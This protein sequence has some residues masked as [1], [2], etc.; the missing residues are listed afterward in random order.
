[1]LLTAAESSPWKIDTQPVLVPGM[2]GEWDDWAIASPTILKR[3]G[4]WWMFYEGVIFDEQ[5]VRSSF[6]TAE[7]T[8][9][10]AW[11]KHSQ[12]PLFTPALSES[13]TCSAPSA[14]LWHDAF[15]AIY[16]VSEDPFRVDLAAQN[17]GDAP[18]TARLARSEDGLIWHD[19]A[20][21]NPPVASKTARAFQPCLYADGDSLHLWW[22]GP[23]AND[24]PAL[25]HSISRDGL[26]WS[27]PNGQPAAEIDAREICCA[28]VYPSGDFFILT[29]VA[30]D[31][32]R[33]ISVV[34]RISRNARSWSALGPPEFPLPSHSMH[35]APWMIFESGGARLFWSEKQK[36]NACRLSSAYCEKKDYASH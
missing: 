17:G 20:G 6:G 33:K 8:D 31:K 12:N 28:R 5:G 1:M 25:L 4:K 22:M 36:N 23:D 32:D 29:Y 11:R 16:L 30:S 24:K 14:T 2:L 21:A 27:K 34:T 35:A 13:Q 9:K 18:V 3:A 26:T 15:W 7:S 19:V 10:L